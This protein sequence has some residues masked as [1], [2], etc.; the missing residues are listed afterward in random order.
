MKNALIAL[1]LVLA[2][3][4]ARAQDRLEPVATF[5]TDP[6]L[7]FYERETWRLLN[8]RNAQWGVLSLPSFRPESSIVYDAQ[9]QALVHTTVEGTT[10]WRA[11]TRAIERAF[12]E[13]NPARDVETAGQNYRAPPVKT[14]VLPV[15]GTLAGKLERLWK[16]ALARTEDSGMRMLDGCVWQFFADGQQG[17]IHAIGDGW[18]RIPR[19][20][21]LLGALE[22]AILS[23]DAGAL[24]AL[25]PEV[26]ALQA[27]FGE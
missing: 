13:G 21:R 5:P 2:P 11:V 4:A 1:L 25:E 15:P 7:G 10:I 27:L 14:T 12:E 3:A 26:D 22:K 20:V 8:A 17:Q 19:L 23:R 6:L 18:T 24:G 16:A 9:A